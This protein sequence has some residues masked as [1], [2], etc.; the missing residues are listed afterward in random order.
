MHL[1]ENAFAFEVKRKGVSKQTQGRF[2]TNVLAFFMD[3]KKFYKHLF[4]RVLL[5]S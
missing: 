1:K 3:F 2:K 4:I 5:H